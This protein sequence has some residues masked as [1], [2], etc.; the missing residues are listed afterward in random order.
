MAKGDHPS[1]LIGVVMPVFFETMRIPLLSGR[2]FGEQDGLKS[3][4]VVIVNQAFARKYFARENPVG[5]HI[6]PDLGD[7]SLRDV[8]REVVGV[9]GDTKQQGLTAAAEPK[10][11]LPYAQAVITNPYLTL[12]T[13]GDPAALANAV[14][15]TVY[16][17]DKSVPVYQVSTLEDYVSKAAA[18]PRFQT[19]LLTC[20]AGT[21]LLLAA[22]GLYG[23]LSYIVT[24][25]TFEIGLRM[26][27]GAQRED[28]L[29]MVLNL[30]LRLA[31][32]GLAIGLVASALGTSFLGHML[33]GVTPLDPI[34]FAAVSIVLLAVSAVASIAPA[35]RA[36]RL[37]PMKTLRDQ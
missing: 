36:S 1:E 31:L 12:R 26:A 25:R 19:L 18:Q 17:M 2:R 24:Q 29:R 10:Y 35:W 37:E 21:A 14:R 13:Q 16:Q 22:V 32:T 7:G 3:Q 20:F 5:K 34:T 11:Y 9:V 30:G 6:G 8:M 15:A 4:P 23:V 33:Y 27:I 28:V